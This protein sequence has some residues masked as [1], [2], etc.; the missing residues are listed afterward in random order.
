MEFGHSC[1]FA[2]RRYIAYCLLA[3]RWSRPPVR[4]VT[5]QNA[6]SIMHPPSL[7]ETPSKVA[8]IEYVLECASDVGFCMKPLETKGDSHRNDTFLLVHACAFCGVCMVFA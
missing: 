6:V 4:V 7:F 8:L 3:G 5:D 1:F 2:W